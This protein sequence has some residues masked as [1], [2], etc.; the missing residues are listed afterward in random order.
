MAIGVMMMM[1]SSIIGEQQ[2]L[3]VASPSPV[4][5]SCCCSSS[6]TRYRPCLAI[7]AGCGS[8]PKKARPVPLSFF[9]EKLMTVMREF[10][11]DHGLELLDGYRRR[12]DKVRR[13]N[14][15]LSGYDRIKQKETGISHEQRMA[16]VTAAWKC[17]DDGKA[18]VNPL[19]DLGYILA[20]G[21]NDKRPVLV[22]F[23]WQTT[24]LTRLIDDPAAK[25]KHVRDRLGPDYAPENLPSVEEAQ[26]LAAERPRAIEEFAKVRQQSE[27]GGPVKQQQARRAKL[28]RGV[29]ILERPA[30]GGGRRTC[31]GNSRLPP[32]KDHS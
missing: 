5:P 23:Y 15:Q 22:D 13:R 19:A 31:G 8:M 12:E 4:C 16:A 25:T 9:K 27:Q 29:R 6:I 1:I 2:K 3:L 30:E 20:R 28:E 21:C 24:A 10:A 26:V 14:R 7:L 18:F 17:S 32:L 11:R